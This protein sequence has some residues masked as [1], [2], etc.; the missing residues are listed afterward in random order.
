MKLTKRDKRTNLEKAI[1]S[2]LEEMKKV[3]PDSVEYTTMATNLNKLYEAQS[4]KKEHVVSPDTVA[5]VVGNIIGIVL[6]LQYE[7]INVVASK[8]L[9]FVLRGRV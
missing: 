1:D 3:E 4:K 2:L 7:K 8:A 6:I 9:G 5:I